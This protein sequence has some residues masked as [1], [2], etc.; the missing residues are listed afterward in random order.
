M[1][2]FA[3]VLPALI[4]SLLILSVSIPASG[5]DSGPYALGVGD[6]LTVSV[7][8]N[9]DLTTTAPVRPDGRISLPLIGDVECV[10]RTTEE[11]REA[12]TTRYAEYINAPAVSV[13]VVEIH[14]RKVYV[15]GEV[16]VPGPY[17]VLQPTRLLQAIAMAG[18]LTEFA[19][20]DG[21]VVI[22]ESGRGFTRREVDLKDITSGKRMQ[23]NL[24]L[25]P[26]DT[27]VVP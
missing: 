14:S 12:V 15:T 7:W 10:G 25:E 16:K 8:K 19:K 18:G 3:R 1:K 20:A 5:A 21:I 22:R 4:F 2:C 24:L 11:L 6:V 26:G 23:D 27:I 9:V 17:D 13:V